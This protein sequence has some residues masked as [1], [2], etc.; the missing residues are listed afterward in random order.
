MFEKG[1]VDPALAGP[2]LD[3]SNSERT[4]GEMEVCLHLVRNLSSTQ[5]GK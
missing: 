4:A 1:V 2:K 5:Y 3:N